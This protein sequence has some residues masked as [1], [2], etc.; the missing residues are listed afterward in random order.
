MSSVDDSNSMKLLTDD[1]FVDLMDAAFNAENQSDNQTENELEK[2]RAW[3]NISE[4]VFEEPH[5][6]NVKTSAKTTL[7]R[8]LLSTAALLTLTFIPLSLYMQSGP[9]ERIKGDAEFVNIDTR[10]FGYFMDSSGDI[11]RSTGRGSIGDTLLFKVSLSQSAYVGLIL[12]RNSHEPELRFVSDNLAATGEILV[13]MDDN[14]YGYK[15][16]ATDKNLEFCALS[17]LNPQDLRRHADNL[18]TKDLGLDKNACVT[19]IVGE[20]N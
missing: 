16:E 14:T 18:I 15:I 12:S 8:R 4:H 11:I 17:M 2:A 7:L 10:L 3:K 9:D 13:Q 6:N 20:Q 5:S 1:D 19:I